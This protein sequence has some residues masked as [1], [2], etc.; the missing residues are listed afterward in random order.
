M[1]SGGPAGRLA[2]RDRQAHV[3]AIALYLARP[4]LLARVRSDL[5]LANY[6]LKKHGDER[7]RGE[8]RVDERQQQAIAAFGEIFR[9]LRRSQRLGRK[10]YTCGVVAAL[11]PVGL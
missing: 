11:I 2:R 4:A 6:V 3:V 7:K 10:T 8:D 1:L 9:R 5:K